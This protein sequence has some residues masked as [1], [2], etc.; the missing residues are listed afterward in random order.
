MIADFSKK[1]TLKNLPLANCF[2]G[3]MENCSE[4]LR[5]QKQKV[6]RE[7]NA[8][9]LEL[10]EELR[11]G[12]EASNDEAEMKLLF[13]RSGEEER[14]LQVDALDEPMREQYYGLKAGF[15]RLAMV[16]GE[17][18][19]NRKYSD[20]NL[21]VVDTLNRLLNDFNENEKTYS[22]VDGNFPIVV[23]ETIARTNTNYL[24]SE[25]L[26]YFNYVYGY[27]FGNVDEELKFTITRVMVETEKDILE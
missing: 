18:V 20:Y 4:K 15:E 7:S 14:E 8:R 13:D 26:T 24:S 17:L 22:R 25:T 2:V 3:R 12:I 19:R 6:V 27:I 11:D 5:A 16:K 21:K 1:A 9:V 10:L 23:K